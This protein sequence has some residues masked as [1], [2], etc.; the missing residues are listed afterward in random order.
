MTK[1]IRALASLALIFGSAGS[2]LAGVR[3]QG[4]NLYTSTKLWSPLNYNNEWLLLI[5][6]YSVFKVN[7]K[8]WDV[9]I[10]FINI[11]NQYDP[12]KTFT[13][14]IDCKNLKFQVQGWRINGVLKE[15]KGPLGI[16]VMNPTRTTLSPGSIMWTAKEYVCGVSNSGSTYYWTYSSFRNNQMRGLIDQMWLRDNVVT[17]SIN[18]S[19]LRHVN[20]MLSVLGGGQSN[21]S[22][23]FVKCDKR[24][25][26][27]AANGVTTTDWSPVPSASGVEVFFEKMCSSRFSFITYQTSSVTMPAPKPAPAPVPASEASEQPQNGSSGM[28]EAKRKCVALG[29]R[30]G[31]PKFGQ[32]VLKLTQ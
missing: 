29:F 32:C 12:E 10:T 4:A 15:Y 24:E 8:D 20:I 30:T 7:Q 6:P 26:M 9:N 18:N 1:L 11:H 21:F 14:R 16:W 3:D 17:I 13:Y 28:D 2:A 27:E 22:E 19:N 25:W 23:F 31:T 5:D